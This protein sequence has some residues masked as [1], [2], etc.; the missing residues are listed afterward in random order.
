MT[1]RKKNIIG[2]DPL[3]WISLDD[4]DDQTGVNASEKVNTSDKNTSKKKPVQ[5][6]FGIDVDS[7]L[8]GYDLIQDQ[9]GEIFAN[10]YKDLF[11]D[12]SEVK[13]L[14]D[15]VDIKN[16]EKK[17]AGAIGLLADNINDVDKLTTVLSALGKSH[18]QYGAKEEHYTAVENTLLAV[19]KKQIGRK[20]TKKISANWATVLSK[21]A[22]VMLDAYNEIDDTIE[23]E[24]SS[25]T[26][27]TG[28]AENDKVDDESEVLYLEAR[29]DISTVSELLDSLKIHINTGQVKIDI[30]RVTRIDASCLQLLYLLVRDA[31]I[32]NYQIEITGTSEAFDRSVFL[33]GMSNML[34]VAV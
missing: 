12:Y 15:G 18:Q 20:W 6:P 3:A 27:D 7:F 2:H 13:P 5:H 24:S 10:F 29:Q 28:I 31:D 30:S 21:A 14:F 1:T 23:L 25:S 19:I 17:L 22:E 34:K 16:Q 32:S 4:E 9:A 33:L 8:L 26:D 11:N